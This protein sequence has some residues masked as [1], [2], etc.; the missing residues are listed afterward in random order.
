MALQRD[1]EINE[2]C[3][4]I[5]SGSEKRDDGDTLA[6]TRLLGKLALFTSPAKSGPEGLLHG[7]NAS[8][9]AQAGLRM[10]SL[11]L[12]GYTAELDAGL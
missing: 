5:I 11:M 12:K 4:M 7:L 8:G 1:I 10:N 6:L 9:W 2:A 3:K